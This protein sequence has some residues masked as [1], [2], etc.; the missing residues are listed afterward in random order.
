MHA[1][2]CPCHGMLALPLQYCVGYE[3]APLGMQAIKAAGF[4]K[5]QHGRAWG[6]QCR[7]GHRGGVQTAGRGTEGWAGIHQPFIKQDKGSE[8]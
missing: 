3:D 6:R 8:P 2:P 4:L 7:D 5:V 1:A